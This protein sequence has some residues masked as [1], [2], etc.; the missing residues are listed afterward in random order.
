MAEVFIDSLEIENFGPYYGKHTLQFGNLD[1]RCGILVGGKNGA[2]KTHLLRALYLAAVGESGVGD[3]KRVEPGSEATRFSFEKSLNR[4]AQAEGQDT[5]RLAIS[6]IQRDERSGSSRKAEFIR[7]IRHRPNSAPI[8]RSYAKKSDTPG[9]IEDENVLQKLRDAFLPRH[10]ARFFF[11]DAERSQSVNLGQQDI[12]DGISRI[13]GLWTYDELEGDLRQLIQNKIP[14]TFNSSAASE[15]ARKLTDLNAEIMRLEGH[16]K[17]NRK[18]LASV[19][20]DLEENEAELL[21]TEDDLRSLGAVNPT[22]LKEAQERRQE[23]AVAKSTIEGQLGAA[24][25]TAMPLGLLGVLRNELT[26][27]LTKEERRRDWEGSKAAVEPKIPRV[28]QDVFEDVPEEFEL[29]SDVHSFYMARL[30]R[31]LNSL[32]NP[33]PD[34]MSEGIFATDRNDISAQ[35]R[36]RLVAPPASLLDLA[37]SSNELENLDGELRDLDQRIRSLQ[38]NSAAISRGGEL[39]EKR[40]ELI[41]TRTTLEKRLE[42]LEADIIQKEIQIEELRREETNQQVV[43]DKAAKGQ[44]LVARAHKYRE[45]VAEIKARAAV[46]LRKQISE[47]VGDLWVDITERDREFLGMEF[48]NHW[49]C[50]LNRRDG[51]KVPWEETNTSAGQRQVRM[52]AFYE[53]LRR[54][55]KIVPPLV[56]DTP[57]AR[58]DK[59]VR[60]SVLEKLYLSGHQSIILSTNSEIDPDG[61]VFDEIG[62]DL[63]RVYTLHPH[64]D[65]GSTDYSVRIT[66]DYFGKQ[67]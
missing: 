53:A 66:S 52:L 31:A 17:A 57:L 59:E 3:L 22:D 65:P 56:V 7:E 51:K 11:F 14:K 67:P 15:A 23:I 40:G 27:Y 63:A 60:S 10:L 43:A 62:G 36:A 12:V 24:W 46:Q 48:D 44:T 1:G 39:H 21:Q 18:E 29:E 32:F 25:E 37:S 9:E 34:G 2:G 38:Q 49:T 30:E 5:I 16:L 64:G 50:F 61:A 6:L 33:P 41:A 4:R 13:L 54:L 35:V 42:A 26:E 45:A 47:H 8:W 58:L 19:Q 20:I 28:K 55:A